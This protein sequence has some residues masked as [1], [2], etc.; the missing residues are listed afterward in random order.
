MIATVTLNPAVDRT[1][2]VRGLKVGDTNRVD[3]SDMDPGGKGINMSLVLRE[4]GADSVALG[5]LGGNTGRFVQSYLESRGIATAFVTVKGETRVNIAVQDG[6]GAPP[7]T[8]HEPGPEISMEDLRQLGEQIR[9][10]LPKC[11]FIAFGGSLPPGA[12]HDVYA[13]LINYCQQNGVKA[14]LDADGT[15]LAAGMAAKPYLVKPNRAEAER[16]LGR[17]LRSLE[18]AASGAVEIVQRGVSLAV[19]SLGVKGAVATDGSEVW[20]A[21]PP[22]LTSKSTVGSG[23]SLLAGFAC[24]LEKGAGLGDALRLG[25]AAGAATAAS[26]G[27]DLATRQEIEAML[28]QVRLRKLS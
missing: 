13:T 20:H 23:D 3:H 25:V 11:S 5:F 24:A 6:T 2:W 18:D 26:P 21:A 12:P 4:C 9:Q 17:A 28:P 27:A 22:V 19:I 10:V 16:L 15:V 8:L 7:T 1:L 14:I